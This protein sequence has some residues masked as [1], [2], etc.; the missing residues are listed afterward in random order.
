MSI[1]LTIIDDKSIFNNVLA[2]LIAGILFWGARSIYQVGKELKQ[3]R[4]FY[5]KVDNHE[6]ILTNHENKLQDHETRIKHLEVPHLGNFGER[7]N[8]VL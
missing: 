1:L 6:K 2:A 7:F 5:T 3:L 8:T 4:E